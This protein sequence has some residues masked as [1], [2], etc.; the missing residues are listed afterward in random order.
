MKLFALSAALV[1]AA[2]DAMQLK[3]R[4]NLTLPERNKWQTKWS[5]RIL[6][7]LNIQ[8]LFQGFPPTKG[9]LVTNHLS[10][11]DIMAISYVLPSTFLSKAEVQ[12]WPF[13]GL[14]T[15]FAGTLFVRRERKS[16]LHALTKAFSDVWKQDSIIVMFP[17]GTSSDGD[18][19]LP[20][21]SSLL[22]PACDESQLITPAHLR[23]DCEDGDLKE[24]VYFWKD[25]TFAPHLLRL[26]STRSVKASITFGEPRSAENQDRKQLTQ[27]LWQDIHEMHERSLE[28][29]NK[30]RHRGNE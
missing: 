13:I 3:L 21:K 6:R 2:L 12:K 11:L 9:M 24:D 8:V 10:Y 1:C 14:L 26:L 15:Q 7:A 29:R 17:E 18:A 5:Q 4:K 27:S 16:D 28:E 25:M 30:Q 20:F 23:Y 19:I 22:K